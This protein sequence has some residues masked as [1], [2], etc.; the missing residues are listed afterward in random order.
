MKSIPFVLARGVGR[1][2]EVC[3]ASRRGKRAFKIMEKAIKY[4]NRMIFV[5]NELKLVWWGL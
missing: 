1:A 3:A 4:Y 2:V 5:L